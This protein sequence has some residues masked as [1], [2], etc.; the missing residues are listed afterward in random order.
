MGF[1]YFLWTLT[2]PSVFSPSVWKVD[3]VAATSVSAPPD[4]H[5]LKSDL[6]VCLWMKCFI[7]PNFEMDEFITNYSTALPSTD[8]GSVCERGGD[9]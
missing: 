6:E 5:T 8:S 3:V 4:I 9:G 7:K 2:V 1:R